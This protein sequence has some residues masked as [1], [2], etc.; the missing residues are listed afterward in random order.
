[1]SNLSAKWYKE[2]GGD[3]GAM[4]SPRDRRK[5]V[6]YDCLQCA[7]EAH[8]ETFK[9]PRWQGPPSKA[10]SKAYRE[11]QADR[12]PCGGAENHRGMYIRL[13]DEL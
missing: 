1:M 5:W 3:F 2:I 9:T 11:R 6:W 12:I 8:P 10:I 7:R 4:K 13:M